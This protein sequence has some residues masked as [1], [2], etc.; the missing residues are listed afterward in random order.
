MLGTYCFLLNVVTTWSIGLHIPTRER[1]N[2]I[3]FS[4]KIEKYFE[5]LRPFPTSREG[6]GGWVGYLLLN[7]TM[8][9]YNL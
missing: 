7:D 9:R 2:E 4:V 3:K 5:L 1:G 6:D 8:I